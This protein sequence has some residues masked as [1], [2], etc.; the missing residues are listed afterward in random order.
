MSSGS[1]GGAKVAGYNSQRLWSC[2][3]CLRAW[4]FVALRLRTDAMLCRRRSFAFLC[5]VA[6][7][8]VV[9]S[10]AQTR[11]WCRGA[12][13]AFVFWRSVFFFLPSEH[14][15]LCQ[16]IVSFPGSFQKCISMLTACVRGRVVRAFVYERRRGVGWLV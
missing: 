15:Q 1:Q 2:A 8:A 7:V 11:R 5:Y 3:R 9:V 6:I 4:C 12:A 14:C 10:W 16:C 13:V